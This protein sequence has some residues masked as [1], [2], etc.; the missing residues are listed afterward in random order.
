M[1][2]LSKLKGTKTRTP[3][4][5]ETGANDATL[6]PSQQHVPLDAYKV[7]ARHTKTGRQGHRGIDAWIE[8]DTQETGGQ[9]GRQAGRQAEG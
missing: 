7:R 2:L 5:H 8:T 1:R 3:P 6:A 4:Y 9:A